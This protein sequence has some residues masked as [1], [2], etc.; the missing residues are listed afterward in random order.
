[1]LLS[2]NLPA[3]AENPSNIMTEFGL[4][5]TWSEDCAMPGALRI[6]YTYSLPGNPAVAMAARN[7]RDGNGTIYFE[8]VSASKV[9]EEKLQVMFIIT[10]KDDIRVPKDR[11][12]EQQPRPGVYE[13]VGQKMKSDYLVLEKCP[14]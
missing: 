11:L 5:G 1:M 9:A 4:V 3:N 2:I 10:G 7:D 12:G 14:N 6:T 13:R 8:V